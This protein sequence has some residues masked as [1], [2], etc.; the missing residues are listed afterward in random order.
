MS[1]IDPK[2]IA[3]HQVMHEI[4]GVTSD[5]GGGSDLT[6]TQGYPV[7]SDILRGNKTLSIARNTVFS[8]AKGRS[9][10][11]YLSTTPTNLKTGIRMP[12]NG[13]VTVISV[14]NSKN[15]TFTLQLRKNDSVTNLVSLA[16]SATL[17][18]HNKI[19]NYDFV[20][21][22]RLQFYI[23]GLSHDPVAWIEIAWRF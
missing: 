10:N 1:C 20:E 16:V 22:D 13:T 2:D 17:G 6:I 4:L 5:G 3:T 11:L 7:F 8:S 9:K 15:N 18:A 12:R 19:V 14:E 23:D 21:G